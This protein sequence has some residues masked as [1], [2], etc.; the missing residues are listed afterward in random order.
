MSALLQK[1]V[2]GEIE[3]KNRAIHAYND[4]LWKIRTGFL[5]LILGGWAIVLKGIVDAQSP[6]MERYRGLVSALLLFSFGF[7]FCAWYIDHSYVRAK[8]RV[9][10]ALNAL[11]D[12]LAGGKE[13]NTLSSLLKVVGSD[14]QREFKCAG[15]CEAKRTELA[16]YLVPLIIILITGVLL[17]VSTPRREQYNFKQSYF[18]TPE[19]RSNV[20]LTL[21]SGQALCQEPPPPSFAG[22]DI[23]PAVAEAHPADRSECT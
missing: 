2:L 11:I 22:P 4:I 1:I 10:L 15:Y 23:V 5:T 20:R 16:I 19:A 14:S 9:I 21:L 7:T 18:A 6:D 13:L 8:F 3:G 12:E 17:I